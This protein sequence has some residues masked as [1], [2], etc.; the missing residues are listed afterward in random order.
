MEF[1]TAD[2]EMLMSGWNTLYFETAIY[3]QAIQ[4]GASSCLLSGLHRFILF[5]NFKLGVISDSIL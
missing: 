4:Q 2:I 3:P 5:V 1:Y